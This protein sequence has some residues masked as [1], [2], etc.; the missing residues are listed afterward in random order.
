MC[1]SGGNPTPITL[2]SYG[3]ACESSLINEGKQQPAWAP[4]RRD[5]G[6]L[7]SQSPYLPE[8]TLP[9]FGDTGN[10]GKVQPLLLRKGPLVYWR[11]RRRH[12]SS[13]TQ[14]P[15][16][17]GEPVRT[18]GGPFWMTLS[19]AGFSLNITYTMAWVHTT[20]TDV[21]YYHF[22]ITHLFGFFDS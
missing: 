4:G 17:P 12:S 2:P 15:Q 1:P 18:F 20:A 5:W 7:G 10:Q 22:I 13:M 6:D 14:L 16:C 11:L 8:G 9:A 21:F 19:I 3:G